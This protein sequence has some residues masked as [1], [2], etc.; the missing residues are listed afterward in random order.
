MKGTNRKVSVMLAGIGGYGALY[1]NRFFELAD[2]GRIEVRGL[3][4]PFPQ[5]C[6]RLDEVERRGWRI[7]PGFDEFY[8]END[9]ELACIATPIQFHT[10]M[11][12]CALAHGSSVI[13]EKPLTGDV[14][15]IERLIEARDRAGRFVMIGYQWSH[16]DA[17]LAMKRDVMSGL[18][19]RPELLKTLILWPRNKAYFNRGSGWAGK[20][21]LGDT[22]VLDSVANN[23]AAHYLHNIFFTLG[24]KLDSALKPSEVTA[25]LFR[26]NPIE[27]FD[28]S[29]IGCRFENGA[30]SLYI[31]SHATK[32][33]LNPIFEYRFDG[34]VITF[35]E[36][37]GKRI[38]GRLANGELR[39]YGDPFENQMKKL[40]YAVE[41]VGADKPFIPCG[42]ETASA[43]VR[44]IADCAE[45]SIVDFPA[46][47]K[48]LDEDELTWVDG[49][50]EELCG[51][52]ESERIPE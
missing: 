42:I 24:S 41:N 13:C 32:K 18:Y 3:V 39:D 51:I 25:R 36:S 4:E 29:I 11:M 19:G 10:E 14:R 23:A 34:G 21:K 16:S 48:R 8:A 49:L 2:E 28:T 44:C 27:N 33:Q 9:C 12:L 50:Y 43:Q 45:R 6:R 15:D 20:K 47:R 38:I 46:E 31:A 22:L 30:R 5:S 1:L 7:Y 52:Y 40:D 17:I 37:V 35:D 26:A